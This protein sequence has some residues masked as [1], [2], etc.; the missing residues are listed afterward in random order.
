MASQVASCPMATTAAICLRLTGPPGDRLTVAYTGRFYDGIRRPST[1]C[2]R[3]AAS[4][5]AGPSR[6][7]LRVSFVGTPLA[8]IA[9]GIGLVLDDVVDFTG[10][11]PFATV[12]GGRMAP[13]FCFSSTRR[14]T[15]A[16]PS[17][18]ARRLPAR[19]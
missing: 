17:Q 8:H 5:D 16:C 1:C 10:R 11:V 15:R 18:Q 9:T 14:P 3:S 4:C 13:T 12:P 19:G 2:A 7:E 6:H